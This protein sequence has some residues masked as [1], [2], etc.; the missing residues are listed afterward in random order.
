[1]GD[2]DIEIYM[3]NFRTFFEKNPK[4]LVQLIGDIDPE[5]FY[6]KVRKIVEKN[7]EDGKQTEPTRQQMIDLI[8]ELNGVPSNLEK[9]M[10][11]MSHHMG[12]ICL[13]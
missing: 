12:L 6:E 13:N 10:P 4:Q 7:T 9:L 2:L 5:K 1:M 11:T 8:L 3:S